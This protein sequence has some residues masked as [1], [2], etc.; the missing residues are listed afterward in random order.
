MKKWLEKIK[1]IKEQKNCKA[2]L[3]FGFYMIFFLVLILTIKFSEK[4]PLPSADEYEKGS[5][6]TFYLDNIA[7]NNYH[8]VYTITQDGVKYE[9][10]GVKYNEQE[11]FKFNLKDY[12][13]NDD[14]FFINN[15][16]WLKN[17][18]PYVYDKFLDINNVAQIIEAAT[19]DSKT[20][21]DNGR[22]IYNFLISSNTLNQKLDNIDSD[23][24]EEPNE[25]VVSTD[26]DKYVEEIIFNLDSY[27][28]MNKFCQN[29]LEIKLAYDRFEEIEEI[30]NPVE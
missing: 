28:T 5:K 3:F 30:K 29:S 22:E 27:C 26:K 25:I 14:N 24:F 2:I 23:Y 20:S 4:R 16:I 8:Y 17:E 21:Y 9:Y 6:Y 1:E 13:R 11:L 15:G 18:S 7:G 19:Y 10:D 12:Y